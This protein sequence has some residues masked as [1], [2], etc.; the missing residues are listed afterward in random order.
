MSTLGHYKCSS[1]GRLVSQVHRALE[2]MKYV[3]LALAQ[4]SFT[5]MAVGQPSRVLMAL[6]STYASQAGREAVGREVRDQEEA[7]FGGGSSKFWRQ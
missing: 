3:D 1:G 6:D 2:V 7:S 5:I 4:G